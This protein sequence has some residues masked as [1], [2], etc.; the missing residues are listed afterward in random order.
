MKKQLGIF[1]EVEQEYNPEVPDPIKKDQRGYHIKTAGVTMEV[2]R[3][4]G[5]HV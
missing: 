4:Q 3:R 2:C 1:N 5:H